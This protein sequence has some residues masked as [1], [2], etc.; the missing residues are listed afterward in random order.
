MKRYI[1]SKMAWRLS[2]PTFENTGSR[3]QVEL[4]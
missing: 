4:W 2:S 1:Y 3:M